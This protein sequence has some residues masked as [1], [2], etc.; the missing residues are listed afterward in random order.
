[1]SKKQKKEELE[2]KMENHQNPITEENKPDVEVKDEQVNQQVSDVEVQQE[3]KLAELT[4]QLEEMK[5]KY[6]RLTAE[7]DNYRKRTLKEKTDILKYASEEVLKDI[8]PVIDD[9]DRALKV[10]DTANDLN[11]VKE[12]ISLIAN[13][14][15]DFLKSKGVKEID[16]IGKDLDTD[17]H[18]AITKIPVQDED[19]KGKIVE[20]IQKGYLLHDK[21]M[22]FSKVV[23][24][25]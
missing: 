4:A 20:V 7:F 22:R 2:Q 11:A 14:F 15:N 21:V 12:G 9:F 19:Q 5:D 16:A 17:L 18:E 25:E 24:G 6:L 10:I 3:D 13:K 23:V 8:L 1:M